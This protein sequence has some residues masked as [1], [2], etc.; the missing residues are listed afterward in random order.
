VLRV[1][2]KAT[3]GQK[4]KTIAASRCHAPSTAEAHHQPQ[5]PNEFFE[6]DGVSQQSY[7]IQRC[8]DRSSVSCLPP[9]ISW[10]KKL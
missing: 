2:Y 3:A 9:Q 8:V 6:A 10:W 4:H 1:F 5:A 7:G